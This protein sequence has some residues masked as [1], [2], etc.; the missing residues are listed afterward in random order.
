MHTIHGLL[1]F[2]FS[3][4]TVLLQS[5]VGSSWLQL[6]NC[7]LPTTIKQLEAFNKVLHVK[8]NIRPETTPEECVDVVN[9][10]QDATADESADNVQVNR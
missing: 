8:F 4:Y 3:F 9:D 10:T 2:S 1:H 5:S 6:D 7:P